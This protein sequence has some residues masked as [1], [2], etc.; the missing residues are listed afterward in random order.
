MADNKKTYSIVINGIQESVKAVDSLNDALGMLENKIKNLSQ[1]SVNVNTT[2]TSGG[3]SRAS[4][5]QTEDK[6]LKQIQQTEQQI[7][8]ARREEYQQLLAE[9]DLLKEVTN[10]A[11][12]R[13]AQERLAAD[14]YA[15]SMEG[16]KQKL[17][18]IKRVMQTTDVGS[19][20]FQGLVKSANELNSKLKELEQSYGQFG[21]N[22][23]NY[24]GGDEFQKLQIEVNGVTREFNNAR[25]ALRTLTNERNT[26]KLMGEDVG[27]LDT[28]VKTLQSDIK[29]MAM[30]SAEMDNLLDSME[31]I[32]AI[33]S[34]G[35]GLAA[36]FGVDDTAIGETIQKL[37]A[38][39]NVLQGIEVIRKQMQTGEGIGGIIAKGNALIDKFSASLLGVSNNSKAA[40]TSLKTQAAATTAVG[41]ASKAA[42][43]A[44]KA[45]SLALKT[46]GIGLVIT[47]IAYLTEA[48]SD[49]LSKE[50]EAEKEAKKLAEVHQEGAKAY[51]QAA[52]EI[53]SYQNKLDTFNGS[54]KQ[55]QALVDELNSKY[56]KALGN[57]KTLAEWKDVLKTKG[58]A[59][60]QTMLK[61]AEAQALLNMYTEAYVNLQKVR[62]NVA[63]GEYHHWWQTK[64]GDAQADA[65][66]IKKAEKEVEKA[67]NQYMAK[68]EEV[69]NFNK[70]NKLFDYSN[71]ADTKDTLKK[72]GTSIGK[73]VKDVEADIA[74]LRVDAMKQGF[75]KTLAQ[76]ELERN[77]RIAEAK[78][79]GKLVSEQISA[80]NTLYNNKIFDARLDY[81]NRLLQEEKKFSD[82]LVKVQDETYRRSY[83]LSRQWNQNRFDD[84]QR[85]LITQPQEGSS[86][87][88]QSKTYSNYMTTMTYDYERVVNPQVLKRFN[89]LETSINIATTAL[90]ALNKEGENTQKTFGGLNIDQWTKRLQ[91]YGREYEKMMKEFPV[92]AAVSEDKTYN[93]LLEA[94]SERSMARQKY[95]DEILS[96]TEKFSERERLLQEE[97]TKLEIEA[98]RKAETE[99][100]RLMA[101]RMYDKDI[102]EKDKKTYATPRYLYTAYT[103]SMDNGYFNGMTEDEIA[104]RMEP[105]RKIMDK[106][107]NNLKQKLEEGEISYEKYNEVVGS[108]LLAAY[109]KQ[110]DEYENYLT[111]YNAMSKKGQEE[112]KA[113]MASWEQAV[114]NAFVEYL[115]RARNEL[116]THNNA[117][118]TLTNAENTQIE[119]ANRDHLKRM[120]Q[121]N[122]D[123]YSNMEKEVEN[124]LS[125]V[126]SKIDK[127]ESRNAW[128]IVNY[129]ATKTALKDLENTVV[130]ALDDIAQ[131]KQQLLEKLKKGEI[132]F[133]DYDTLISQLN[134]VEKQAKDSAENIKNKLKEL[135]VT[136]WQ[137][138]DQWVQAAGQSIN[139]ILSSLSEITSNRYDAEIE[140][141]Q[142]Y[143]DEYEE[144]LQKQEEITQEH[145]S[146]VNSIEDEL[147][148]ARGDRRQHLID[149][150]NAEMAA[151]R[152]S[153]AQEKKIQ[154]EKEAAEKKQK[155]LEHDQAVAKKKMQL[156]QAVINMAMAISMA[157]VN[158]WP[159][160]AIPMMA[161]A[162]AAGA[163]QIAAIQSQN[164]PSYGEG[165]VIQGKSHRE[166]GVKVLGGRAEVEGGEFITNKATTEQNVQLLEYINTK[167]RR[168][169]LDDMIE[170][171]SNGN[172]IKK[173]ISTVRTKFAD[174]G[175]IP[176]MR[177]DIDMTDRLITAFEDYS[178]RPQI[179]SVVDI[180]DRT[181]AVN[182]IRTLA[183]LED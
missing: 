49:W 167:K 64:A 137:S 33:A 88:T 58:E 131:Q 173:N 22:V 148:T 133:G 77:K 119:Q 47:A 38:L 52:G 98:L 128:G 104:K 27:E 65:E 66:E 13:A 1:A 122:T 84:A 21:R 53:K 116:E 14:T 37:V 129:K 168:V 109:I 10:E 134:S 45:L 61:E 55:E 25:E 35:E 130:T 118:T 170:F 156:A 60:C 183:G 11:Q 127:A 136:W 160:P 143:I 40:S 150:L 165:G 12:Q 18:D 7:Q 56:G 16:M 115:E 145:A 105:S 180:I 140:Q 177:T 175:Q 57:Y 178:N 44:V 23:G 87:Y 154:R 2:S 157:A 176:Y 8:N 72:G 67:M 162:G 82:K 124:V 117:M 20:S 59:Y 174:G 93:T 164:I 46:V 19:D 9:K 75:T 99:R 36:F 97:N 24:N 6:L 179:V 163:A 89:Q 135:S 30:S 85:T 106:W 50:S 155:K 94:Y 74:K 31:G 92:L 86:G 123:Y 181:Q 172:T 83:E 32:V 111:Q 139:S 112:N 182:E 79:T 95:Y 29:D 146:N 51:A 68:M 126:S 63:Q 42:T 78:K 100:H 62:D 103:Q 153:L 41:T 26:L 39:Q 17:S 15:N 108:E 4:E 132:T 34:A 152:A 169:N 80:I 76:L 158:S 91:E 5:L 166:G 54:K 107:I 28:V 69:Q 141:M 81:Y 101:S 71:Y 144:L 121:A 149:Q 96:L 138:I 110:K 151:Q 161:L 70:N 114:N 147:K 171:Y 120:Q 142:K 43:V 102:E 3:S 113:A 48:I 73:T 125:S 90:E 159:I